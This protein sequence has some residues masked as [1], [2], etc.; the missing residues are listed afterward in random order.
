MLSAFGGKGKEGG[1]GSEAVKRA[2][3]SCEAKREPAGDYVEKIHSTWEGA[4]TPNACARTHANISKHERTYASKVANTPMHS[5]RARLSAMAEG[6]AE[7][8]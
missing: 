2:A 1:R 8:L 7:A 5:R 6:A 4:C 3:E